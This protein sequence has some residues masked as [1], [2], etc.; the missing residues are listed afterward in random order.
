[1]GAEMW[2]PGLQNVEPDSPWVGTPT[3]TQKLPACQRHHLWPGS[4][5]SPVQLSGKQLSAFL[6][7]VPT[8]QSQETLD[9]TATAEFLSLKD[10]Y[11]NIYGWNDTEFGICFWTNMW[12]EVGGYRWNNL[13]HELIIVGCVMGA[14]GFTILFYC[15]ACLKCS[16]I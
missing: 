14:W 11:W 8:N 2:S 9:K 6:A 10:T 1:M 13:G 15:F 16:I 5:P 3:L 12:E 4:L 7:N